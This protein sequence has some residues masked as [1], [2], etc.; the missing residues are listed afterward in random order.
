LT[1]PEGS[2][3]FDDAFRAT[4]ETLLNW[5]RD[6]RHFRKEALPVET[7]ER[8]LQLAQSA[9]SVGNSQPWRFVRIRSPLLRTALADHADG[10]VARAGKLYPEGDRR[11]LYDRLKLHGL[12]DAPEIMAVFCDQ[13][14]MAGHNLGAASMPETRLYSTVMAIHTLWLAARTEGVGLGWVSVVDPQWVKAQL[15]VPASWAFVALLCLGYPLAP[16]A[17]P[18]LETRG[19][20]ARENWRDHISER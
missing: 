17:V 4:F 19:W 2:P 9:P 3:L 12:R 13:H 14:V 8:L 15:D 18:E 16:T 1:D 6:V 20:Q 11:K 5:R 10:E 7:T